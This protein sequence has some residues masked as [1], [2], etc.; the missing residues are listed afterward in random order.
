MTWG[1]LNPALTSWRNGINDLFPARDT[2]TDGAIADA[3][4]DSDSEHQ[5]DQDKLVDAF[6]QDV[7]LLGSGVPTG[8]DRERALNEALKADFQADPRAHLWISRSQIASH[9]AS[10]WK[11]RAYGGPSPHTEHTHYE[12]HEQNEGDGRPWKF[13]HT[14]AKMEELGL[15]S[16][17]FEE[18]KRAA[19]DG[20][21]EWWAAEKVG[22]E[23]ITPETALQ[24]VHKAVTGSTGDSAALWQRLD[25]V[26]KLGRAN[27]EALARIEAML[28]ERPV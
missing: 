10:N 9:D 8:D 28:T 12:S 4:H 11:R 14:I 20:A 18:T 3:D 15:M 22:A 19:R 7:N 16:L 5:P 23:T 26:E 27:A 25:E 13:T 6:D 1:S 17:D 21:A 2:R 24:R